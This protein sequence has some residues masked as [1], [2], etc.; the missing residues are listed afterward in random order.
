MRLNTSSAVIAFAGRLEE[1][2]AAF[3]EELAGLC[4][5]H[6]G[7]L[8]DWARENRKNKMRIERAYYG[9]I[10]DA[11]EGSFTFDL[12]ADAYTPDGPPPADCRAAPA[13][14]LAMEERVI[15][16]YREAARQSRALLADI[17]GVMTALAGKREA[18]LAKLA[19]LLKET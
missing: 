3:Y 19:S 17:P 18:R 12:A 14:A 9:V 11:I 15:A 4:P 8:K 1:E 13:W 2:A 7:W 16:F 10:T 5:D 6:A